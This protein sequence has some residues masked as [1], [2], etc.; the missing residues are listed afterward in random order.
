MSSGI[1]PIFPILVFRSLAPL[2]RGDESIQTLVRGMGFAHALKG[3]HTRRNRVCCQK[4]N[5][6]NLLPGCQVAAT[7]DSEAANLDYETITPQFYEPILA[8]KKCYE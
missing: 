1:H 5:N 2:R 7:P 8:A 6:S 4:F 3:I